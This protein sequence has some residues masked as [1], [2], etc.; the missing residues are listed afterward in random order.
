MYSLSDVPMSCRNI[1][2]T[3]DGNTS[4]LTEERLEK[5]R[6]F[7]SKVLSPISLVVLKIRKR[8]LAQTSGAT[9]KSDILV[10]YNLNTVSIQSNSLITDFSSKLSTVDSSNT[11]QPQLLGNSLNNLLVKI[12]S[13][14]KLKVSILSQIQLATFLYV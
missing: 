13:F 2:S 7:L 10:D 9:G 14:R 12:E 5:V 11:Q 6:N 4:Q 8:K 3:S 1:L